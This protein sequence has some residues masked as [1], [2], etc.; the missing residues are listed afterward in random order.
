MKEIFK[1]SG[2]VEH[3]CCHAVSIMVEDAALKAELGMYSG[4]VAEFFDRDCA[5][6]VCR[7]MNEHWHERQKS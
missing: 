7:L 6:F 2:I 1:V 5:E 4:L 3:G